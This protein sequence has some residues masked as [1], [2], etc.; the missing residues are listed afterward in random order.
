M[1]LSTLRN[2]KTW[3]KNKLGNISKFSDLIRGEN[4]NQ[5]LL[6]NIEKFMGFY[7]NLQCLIRNKMELLRGKIEH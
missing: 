3:W 6:I 2:S 4:T 1:F 7:N 5:E